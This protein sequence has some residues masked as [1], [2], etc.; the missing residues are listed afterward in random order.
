MDI[1]DC[2]DFSNQSPILY[3]LFN[4]YKKSEKI[5]NQINNELCQLYTQIKQH[6]NPNTTLK[7]RIAEAKKHRL[8]NYVSALMNGFSTLLNVILRNKIAET[9]GEHSR[10]SLTCDASIL[11]QAG[12]TL[13]DLIHGGK[14]DDHINHLQEI[15]NIMKDL[16]TE[17]QKLSKKI[18]A[19][20][21]NLNFHI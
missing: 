11:I 8:N 16:E 4:K 19:K 14:A 5:L 2:S 12:C 21:S 6:R 1:D 13:G 15:L 9:T 3:E 7:N 10:S 20:L 18:S 17:Q